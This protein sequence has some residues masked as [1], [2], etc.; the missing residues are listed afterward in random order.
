MLP[1]F[2]FQVNPTT[3][4]WQWGAATGSAIICT[5]LFIWS[6][7]QITLLK[8]SVDANTKTILTNNEALQQTIIKQAEM[9]GRLAENVNKLVDTMEQQ[10][11]SSEE[12]LSLIHELTTEQRVLAANQ[13]VIMNGFQRVVE[14]LIQVVKE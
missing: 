13:L 7:L 14:Q 8:N 3:P 12:K 2:L 9:Q 11:K 1:I 6:Q 10:V 5:G 4:I